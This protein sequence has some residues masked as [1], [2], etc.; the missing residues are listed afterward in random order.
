MTK[1][2]FY[3]TFTLTVFAGFLGGLLSGWLTNTGIVRA[4]SEDVIPKVIRAEKFVVVSPVHGANNVWDTMATLA[5]I[6][7]EG[8]LGFN[9]KEETH[10]RYSANGF[11]LDGII[12]KE[13]GVLAEY[14]A[15]LKNGTLTLGLHGTNSKSATLGAN[16]KGVALFFTDEKQVE[17]IGIGFSPDGGYET[18][19]SLRDHNEKLRGVF[20][21]LHNGGPHIQLLDQN[22]TKRVVLYAEDKRAAIAISDKYGNTKASLGEVEGLGMVSP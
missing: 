16:D 15:T 7:G 19:I 4:Q 2:Q 5:H 22:A 21:I 13:E 20:G 8:M 11:Y 3:L 18:F 1:K 17:R 14:R 10:G 9:G 12:S 6:D